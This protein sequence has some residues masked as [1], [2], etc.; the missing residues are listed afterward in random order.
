LLGQF[1]FGGAGGFASGALGLLYVQDDED[2]T[3]LFEAAL[4]QKLEE[5]VGKR[6]G[7]LYRD[8]T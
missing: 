1:G 3:W 6:V 7:S 8:G 2:G 5:V 4:G